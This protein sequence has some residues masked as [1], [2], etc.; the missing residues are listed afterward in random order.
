[1]SAQPK[2]PSELWTKISNR[3]K[4]VDALLRLTCVNKSM[5]KS[6]IT[7][8]KY[9]RTYDDYL[10][11]SLLENMKIEVENHVGIAMH[12]VETG[13][14]LETG[15]PVVPRGYLGYPCGWDVILNGERHICTPTQIVSKLT[16]R[17]GFVK[18]IGGFTFKFPGDV[19]GDE[20]IHEIECW[21]TMNALGVD[22]V[23]LRSMNGERMISNLDPG[24]LDLPSGS[25]ILDFLKLFNREQ[26]RWYH[27]ELIPEIPLPCMDHWDLEDMNSDLE[28]INPRELDDNAVDDTA[29]INCVTGDEAD[30]PE[31]SEECDCV[32]VGCSDCIIVD[33]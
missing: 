31:E 4:D 18:V 19:P 7:A 12:F 6:T 32:I 24:G 26:G 10:F 14:A 33:A 22:R 5:Q 29:N 3:I 2:L 8:I 1:M 23:V 16:V 20:R 28:A 27:R 9:A 13:R 11:D 15:S 21:A 17:S 30:I 25:N